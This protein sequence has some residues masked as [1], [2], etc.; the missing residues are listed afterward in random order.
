M[1]VSI[2]QLYF[3]LCKKN[4]NNKTE[5]NS[6]IRK[7]ISINPAPLPPNPPILQKRKRKKIQR[8]KNLFPIIALFHRPSLWVLSCNCTKSPPRDIFT[9]SKRES[10]VTA[11][12]MAAFFPPKWISRLGFPAQKRCPLSLSFSVDNKSFLG[13]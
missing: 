2:I 9:G 5:K 1:E 7:N 11:D 8:K 6:V 10:N 4:N 13:R 12:V 3:I